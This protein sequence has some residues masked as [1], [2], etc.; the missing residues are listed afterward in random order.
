M[1]HQ[2][3]KQ[4]E[5]TALRGLSIQDLEAPALARNLA[6][7]LLVAVFFGLLVLI[8]MPWQQ[9]VRGMGEVIAFSPL[10]RRQEIE[11]PIKGRLK[12]WYVQEGSQVKK[13]DLM[14]VVQDNDPE[15]VS[16][17]QR[18]RET[19]VNQISFNQ[20]KVMAYELR[21]QD[22]AVAL[23]ATTASAQAKLESTRAKMDLEQR[24]LQASEA[25]LLTAR[26]N[27]ERENALQEK[28][29]SSQRSNE[30]ATLTYQKN[31][32]DVN[33]AKAKITSAS[34]DIKQAQ[35]DKNKAE[36]SSRAQINS[37]QASLEESRA[38]LEKSHA[39]LLKLETSLAR[40]ATQEVRAP[41]DGTILKLHTFS[42]SVFVKEGEK[43]ATLVPD[44][45]E[46]AVELYMNGNDVP[47]ITAGREVRLQFEGWPALQFSGWPSAAVGTFGGEVVL[48]D[49]T[50]SKD[51]KFRIVVR[52]KNTQRS[53]QEASWPDSRFLRQG[54]KV[55]GWVLLDTVPVGYEL[56]RQF[57]GF[58][59]RMEQS[60]KKDLSD[61]IK[62]K[63]KK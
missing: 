4:F 8:W 22:Y 31:L 40:Q 1:T 52:P 49:A 39:E 17:L 14:V 13:G 62:R 5:E 55:K 58:P 59:P 44:T 34:F 25:G 35:A 23:S 47:L 27:L 21:V 63:S 46:R 11:S 2:T 28:G 61:L 37:A 18:Q 3:P 32:A 43:L 38:S 6:W 29:L 30:L 51:G 10:E 42:E 56:W 7:L 26:L 50:D 41:R 57:N 60:S 12:A 15:Y 36:A 54:V 9:N 48:V 20:S 19:L 33:K 16:R 53:D 24:E 45:Q